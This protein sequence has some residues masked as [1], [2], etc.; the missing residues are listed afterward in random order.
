[1]GMILPPRHPGHRGQK[2]IVNSGETKT[3]IGSSDF[4]TQDAF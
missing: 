3:E 4:G 1:M 2:R